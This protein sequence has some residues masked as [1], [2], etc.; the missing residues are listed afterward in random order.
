MGT[1]S[2]NTHPPEYI[3]RRVVVNAHLLPSAHRQGGGGGC[4]ASGGRGWGSGVGGGVVGRDDAA[5]ME[6]VA[7][8]QQTLIYQLTL[9]ETQH[10]GLLLTETTGSGHCLRY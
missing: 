5:D 9:R 10:L 3:H 7:H 4:R 8:Q 2:Q 6:E 1:K